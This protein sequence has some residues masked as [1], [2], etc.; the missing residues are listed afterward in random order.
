MVG[1]RVGLLVAAVA[2]VAEALTG[3]VGANAVA[4]TANPVVTITNYASPQI[5]DPGGIAVANDGTVFFSN[6]NDNTI[7]RRTPAGVYSRIPAGEQQIDTQT[8][9]V[10][11]SHMTKQPDGSILYVE[12]GTMCCDG[13]LADAGIGTITSG[14]RVVPDLSSQSTA[15]SIDVGTD[16]TLWVGY[17]SGCSTVVFVCSQV[18]AGATV[19]DQGVNVD[20]TAVAGGSNGSGWFFN[21]SSGWLTY[22]SPQHALTEFH[23]LAAVPTGGIEVGG[24]GNLWFA[25]GNAIGRITPAGV[26][27]TF[28]APTISS[29]LGLVLGP[30]G[31]IWF[32]NNGNNSIGRITPTGAV[33]NYTGAGIDHP[34]DLAVAPDG[35]IWFVNQGNHTLGRINL[36]PVVVPGGATVVE[37]NSGTVALQVPVT[38]SK[39]SSQTVT[40]QWFTGPAGPS[41]RADPATDFSAASGTVTFAPGETAK[42]VAITVNGDTLVEPNEWITIS[43]NHPTNAKM[44]GFYGLG[45]G[46]I[47]ND[48]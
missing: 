30:D 40:V 38:L 35:D 5:I 8:F 31:N 22:V 37:G 39:P 7:G 25:K 29:P 16:G 2:L 15:P 43:F 4:G 48:D 34:T 3:T 24:D 13:L 33:T 36:P 41:P 45:F 14:G 28:T 46:V 21:F 44:G 9:Q 19:V 20:P 18:L 27:T 12:N 32:S 23:D 11:P 6:T 1:K 42:T 10:H 47:T 17:P 26:V